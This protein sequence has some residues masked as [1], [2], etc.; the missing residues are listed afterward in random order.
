MKFENRVAVITGGAGYIGSAVARK[1]CEA[2]VAVAIADISMDKAEALAAS[3]RDKGGNAKAFVMDIQ[4]PA[5]IQSAAKAILAEFGHADILINN[6]GVWTESAFADMPEDLWL[7]MIDTNLN[8]VFR[9]TKAFIQDM[10]QNGYGRVINIG[11][12]AGKTG[13]PN[14]CG[15]SAAKAG[16][17]M[18]TKVLAMEFAGN[19]ITVNCVSPGMIG[20]QTEP[21]KYT[22]IGRRGTNDE[23]A[24]LVMFLAS[25]DSSFITGADYTIDGG[26]TLGPHGN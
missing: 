20:P 2:G 22:W 5:E 9:V 23:V 16:V 18:L 12:I 19:N 26:R 17:Q 6:A 1:L 3:L 25:D 7:K 11:S 10:L 13:I 8:S 14:Y 24:D 21:T 4:N 15:Y